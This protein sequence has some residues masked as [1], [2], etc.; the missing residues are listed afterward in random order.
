MHL[1]IVEGGLTWTRE[2]LRAGGEDDYLGG[3][4]GVRYAWSLS[5]TS[6]FEERLAWY[7]SFET[8]DDWR[9]TSVT[10][11]TA[12]LND[13]LALKLGYEVA[14]DNEPVRGFEDTDTTTTM[15]VVWSF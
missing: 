6:S 2:D 4:V 14:Y 11:L 5:D 1:L 9:L 15:S 13:A 7:P 8:S 10:S 12:D 3:L